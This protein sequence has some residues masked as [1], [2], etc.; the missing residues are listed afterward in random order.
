MRFLE[1]YLTI[2]SMSVIRSCS[3]GARDTLKVERDSQ[4]SR[5]ENA[6]G[7]VFQMPD[8]LETEEKNLYLPEHPKLVENLVELA[9]RERRRLA[10][11]EDERET[12]RRQERTLIEQRGAADGQ[13]RLLDELAEKRRQLED[14]EARTEEMARLQADY[15]AAEKVLHHIQPKRELLAR[16]EQKLQDAGR[17]MERLRASLLEQEEA[18]KAA[19]AA[20]DADDGIIHE[21]ED[22]KT[23]LQLLEKTLP[24]YEELDGKQ[25]EKQD[26]ETEAHRLREQISNDEGAREREKDVLAEMQAEQAAYAGVDAQVVRLE[27]EYMQAQSN[28]KAL[29]DEKGIRN[30]IDEIFRNKKKLEEQERILQ[31][32]AKDAAEAERDHHRLYQAFISGQAGL[33]AEGLRK[34]LAEHRKAACPVCHTELCAEQAH[35]FAPLPAEMPAQA[36][37]DAA[38]QDYDEK[39]EKRRKQDQKAT[40][41]RLSIDS[42]VERVLRDVA[43]LFPECEGWDMLVREGWLSSKIAEFQRIE[44]DRKNALEEGRKKQERSGELA[45]QQKQAEERIAELDQAISQGG[46]A[47][48]AHRLLAGKLDAAISA[49][50]DQ[51]EYPDKKTADEQIHRRKARLGVLKRQV[52]EHLETL[53]TAA[54]RRDKTQGTLNGKQND[55]PDLEQ[56]RAKAEEAL[57]AVLGENGFSALEEAD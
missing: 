4:I 24:Y 30:R 57:Q 13:N 34:E 38:R 17:E 55:L 2:P 11:L 51:L 22:L 49:L 54:S 40:A 12:V 25:K 31:T 16:T 45:D 5:I 18:V 7:A 28:T 48:T 42:E 15:D 33:L 32:L 6:M 9:E 47:L 20:A 8:G 56:S 14:L 36:D 41:L 37:V 21:I 26:A 35:E 1:N 27:H 3:G 10:D 52:K 46:K 23:E 29:T 43:A 50:L 39:E 19:Q 44:T 53:Q